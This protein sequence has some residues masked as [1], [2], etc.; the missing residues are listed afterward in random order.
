MSSK[1]QQVADFTLCSM[2]YGIY[3]TRVEVSW[4]FRVTLFSEALC[5]G[6]G[7]KRNGSEE[8]TWG[9]QCFSWPS[10]NIEGSSF[11]DVKGLKLTTAFPSVLRLKNTTE[12]C[13]F[14]I[15]IKIKINRMNKQMWIYASSL[16]GPLLVSR[17]NILRE[18]KKNEPK[19]R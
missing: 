5:L 10:N 4:F 2:M 15:Y 9:S 12:K 7:R 14:I 18:G 1:Y 17:M 16:L 19:T 11:E 6:G 8:R 3:M 13:N